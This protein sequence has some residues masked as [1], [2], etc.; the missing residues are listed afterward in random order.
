MLGGRRNGAP[1]WSVK[2]PNHENGEEMPQTL[3][4]TLV[5]CYFYYV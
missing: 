4:N 1:W 2:V 3:M 5:D